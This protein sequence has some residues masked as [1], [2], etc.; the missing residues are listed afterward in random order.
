MRNFCN[1]L[2]SEQKLTGS[3][4][5]IML[6]EGEKGVSC[7]TMKKTIKKL[8]KVLS[9]LLITAVVLSCVSCFTVETYVP[10]AGPI[11][12]FFTEETE[13]KNNLEISLSVLCVKVEAE[14]RVHRMEELYKKW[15]KA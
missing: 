13:S 15:P 4:Y 11:I 7:T 3:T 9:Y 1:P 10:R 8:K 12:I 2:R 5:K 14:L 6:G